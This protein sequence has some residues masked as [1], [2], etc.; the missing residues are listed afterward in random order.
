[1]N[2]KA[3]SGGL[4]LLSSLLAAP[5]LSAQAASAKR[6]SSIVSVAVEEYAKGV[7]EHGKLISADEY[8]ETEGFLVDARVIAEKMSSYEAPVARAVLDT[9]ITAVRAKRPPSEVRLIRQRFIGVLGNAGAMDMP[10]APLDTAAGHSLFTQNCLSCHG[11]RG[12]GDG[13]AAR[14]LSTKV[15]PI[16]SKATTPEL[17]PALAYNVITVGIRNTAMVPFTTLTPQQR[18]NIVNYV[19]TLRGEPMRLPAADATAAGATGVSQTILALL[20]SALDFARAGKV[21]EAGDRAFDAYIAFEPLETPTSA[22]RPALVTTMERHFA[23][24]KGAVKRRDISGAAESRDRIADGLPEVIDL[25]QRP[26]TSWEAFLQSFLIIL[27]E[28]FEAILVI[29]AVVAFLIKMGHRERL[30]SIWIG[31]VLGLVASFATAVVMATALKALPASRE[32]VEGVTM[33]IAVVVLFSVSY[34]LISRVE[35]AKW[36][37]FIREKVTNAL[38]HG[39][40]KAL[41]LVSF[42]AVYREGAETALFYQALFNEGPSVALPLSLGIAVGFVA[43]AVIFTLFYRYGVRIPMRPFF[44]VTSVLLYYMAFVFAGKGIRELQEGNVVP[45][46]LVHWA[47]HIEAMGVYPSV[48]SLMAQALLLVLFVFMIVKT[49][50]PKRVAA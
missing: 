9:L 20:D 31:I 2:L 42:L 45:I 40:G 30:R 14:G 24:F 1:M 23:D 37:Q 8:Q 26:S 12:M 3:F 25:T 34:W 38:D 48:Q 27:R 50:A 4:L 6:V 21:A 18:W 28:G 44:T 41:V 47:P 33:L 19:Y 7:D 11:A 32:I 13:V 43:L 15:P 16:G 10:T 29:G 46:T 17:T 39:G 36:Q 49:F 22:K 35:A 5:C